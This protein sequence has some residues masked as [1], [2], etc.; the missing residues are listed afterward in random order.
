MLYINSVEPAYEFSLT[1]KARP[2]FRWRP[3]P[4]MKGSGNDEDASVPD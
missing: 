4:L 2:F 3:N 1:E